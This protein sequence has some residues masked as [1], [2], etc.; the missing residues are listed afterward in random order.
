MKKISFLLLLVLCSCRVYTINDYKNEMLG[1]YYGVDANRLVIDYGL[2]TNAYNYG[3]MTVYEFY[4]E[5][6]QYI[7]KTYT[8]EKD[9]YRPKD[10][11]YSDTT[12]TIS[13]E[14]GY[15]VTYSCKTIFYLTNGRVF[16][17][18]FDGNDCF[19]SYLVWD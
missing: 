3:N 13:E 5:R 4:K 6:T 18:R 9:N 14:G 8:V 11:P 1:K 17:L 19:K 15:S 7:P 10:S 12:V 2:P 16:D